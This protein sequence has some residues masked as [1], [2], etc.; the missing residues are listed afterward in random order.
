MFKHVKKYTRP[1]S[2][3]FWYTLFYEYGQKSFFN[4]N[5]PFEIQEYILSN[6]QFRRPGSYQIIM[7]MGTPPYDYYALD[8]TDTM[9]ISEW[10]WEVEYDKSGHRKGMS[11][12]G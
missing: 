11:W 8:C 3:L 7:H 9:G 12:T 6:P 4:T 1:S 10:V 2:S 5:A